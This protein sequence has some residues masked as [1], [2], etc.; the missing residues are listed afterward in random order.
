MRD[1]KVQ[2]LGVWAKRGMVVNRP[3]AAAAIRR[4][5]SPVTSR[6]VSWILP[7]AHPARVVSRA[8]GI[9]G[10][11]E[12]DARLVG[13]AFRCGATGAMKALRF[14]RGSGDED[15]RLRGD[16]LDVVRDLVSGRRD[17]VDHQLR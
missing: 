10:A 17:V 8:G 3:I 15:L 12:N 2:S 9:G 14:P 7:E 13:E 5:L 1:L 11:H 16:R 6:G 4:M